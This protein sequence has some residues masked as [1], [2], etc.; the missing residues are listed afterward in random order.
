MFGPHSG[1]LADSILLARHLLYQSASGSGG[2]RHDRLDDSEG[3]T[4]NRTR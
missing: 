1:L 3:L 4:H 2:N